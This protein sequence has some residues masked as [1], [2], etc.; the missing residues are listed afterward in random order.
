[1]LIAVITTPPNYLYQVYLED[2]FPSKP[3]AAKGKKDGEKACEPESERL[4]IFNT[5]AK[6]FLD[7]SIGAAV[8]TILFIFLVGILKGKGLPQITMDIQ[9][10]WSAM[11]KLRSG[12]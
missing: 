9:K 3:G 1:M 8:N 10:V 4:S 7:Q 2:T 5:G 6:F 12:C 11:T